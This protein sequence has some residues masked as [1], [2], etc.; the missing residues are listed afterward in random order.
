MPLLRRLDFLSERKQGQER[1]LDALNAEWNTDYGDAED[2]PSEQI[3][4]EEENP[5]TEKDPE[6]IA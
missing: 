5:S 6:Y 2:Y 1:E 4:Q 3:L